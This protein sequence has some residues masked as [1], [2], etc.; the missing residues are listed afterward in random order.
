MKRSENRLRLP[1]A[2]DKD[3]LKHESQRRPMDD[4]AWRVLRI[5]AE[6]VEGF[7]NLRDLGPAVSIFG[8]A[9]TPSTDPMYRAAQKTADLLAR[10][11]FGV[12]TGGGPG[13]M[14]AA[15][16]GA[17]P[18]KG[19]SIGLNIELPFEQKPNPY[20]NVHLENRYF[21]ARKLLFVKY[22]FSFVY[23]PGG[24]GTLDELFEVATLVQTGKID[25]YPLILFGSRHWAP[26]LGWIRGTLLEGGF[27]SREDPS[28]LRVVDRPEEVLKLVRTQ[29]K[30]MKLK[31]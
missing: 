29:A 1:G 3:L 2:T 21:F 5:Q 15:N 6:I 17:L 24:L 10:A 12:I 25:R 13:I 30:K 31:P 23:F 19:P 16:K 20:L 11:G 28:I 27:I 14:E 9:R 7:E 4:E 8:S 26:L 22:A 18:H